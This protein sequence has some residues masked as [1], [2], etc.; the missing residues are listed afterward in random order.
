MRKD[1]AVVLVLMA[2]LAQQ[3]LQLCTSTSCPANY[4]CNANQ[5]CIAKRDTLV[6]T[7]PSISTGAIAG[8]VLGW[9]FGLVGLFLLGLWL[10][11]YYF[12]RRYREDEGKSS[13]GQQDPNQQRRQRVETTEQELPGYPPQGPPPME[14]VEDESKYRTKRRKEVPMDV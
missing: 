10:I 11:F 5:Y 7:E 6:Q 9:L 1:A 12:K 8:I 2:L 13:E 4:V 3:T 14:Y